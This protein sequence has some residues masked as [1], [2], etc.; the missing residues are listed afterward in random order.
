MERQLTDKILMIRPANFGFN[1]ETAEDNAFQ[2]IEGSEQIEDIKE[3]AIKEF[4]HFVKVLEDEGVTVEVIEDTQDPVKYDSV[5]P[6]NWISFHQQGWIITYPM[7]SS[8]RRQ[9]RREDI[10]DLFTEKYGFNKRYSFEH[11]EEDNIFLEGTG[12]LVLDRKNKIAYA[13]VSVRTDV[14]LLD[15]WSVLTGYSTVIFHGRD[16]EDYPIY[17]TNVL[18][19]MGDD[20]VVICMDSIKNEEERQELL[21]TFNRTHKEVIMIDFSQ[22]ES[23]AGNM[24]QLDTASGSIMVMSSQAYQSLNEDQ[25]DKISNYSRIV[26]AD[27]S[28]IEK[29]GGGSVRC[30]MAELF[31]PE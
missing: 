22:M 31:T 8:I 3:K 11:Y 14:T 5:F 27:I 15:K 19:A 7:F 21:A 2:S 4:D 28:C 29:Y 24:L 20:F 13:S 30:M 26:H 9:E 6:N 10:V 23:F 17:H 12:S 18:M 16:R 25:V 1:P